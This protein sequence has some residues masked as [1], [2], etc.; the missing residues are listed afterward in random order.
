MRVGLF[1]VIVLAAV[2]CKDGGSLA[3]GGSPIPDAVVTTA[4]RAHTL[5]AGSPPIENLSIVQVTRASAEKAS[6]RVAKGN[7][8]DESRTAAY[9]AGRLNVSAAD[10]ANGVEER[11]GVVWRGITRGRN[12]TARDVREHEVATRFRSGQWA[13]AGYLL[14]DAGAFAGTGDHAGIYRAEDRSARG[15]FRCEMTLIPA[16]EASFRGTYR[17][18]GK[19]RDYTYEPYRNVRYEGTIEKFVELAWTPERLTAGRNVG[20]FFITRTASGAQALIPVEVQENGQLIV[21]WNPPSREEQGPSRTSSLRLR[22]QRNGAATG[23]AL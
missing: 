2:S 18:S 14:T 22:F 3:F 7:V 8:D 11:V 6:A 13:I 17:C 4:I 19:H 5:A 23:G 12:G 20:A 16:A 21:R 9:F 15:G 1:L 10:T